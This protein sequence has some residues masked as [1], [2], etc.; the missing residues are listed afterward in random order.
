MMPPSGCTF[1]WARAL[2][3][4][5]A[6]TSQ[7]LTQSEVLKFVKG[8]AADYA[9]GGSEYFDAFARDAS[10][11]AVSVPTRID[12]LEEYKSG[13]QKNFAEGQNRRTQVLSPEV[14]ILGDDA[15]LVTFHNRIQV[16]DV[17]TNNRVTMVIQRD[18]GKLEVSHLHVS[19]LDT[20]HLRPSVDGGR[21]VSVLEER[22]AT[23]IGAVGTPK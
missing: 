8:F 5:V 1:L 15:A 19:P 7:A 12:S 6:M 16:N 23:A 20:P 18:G 13:F 9:A 3:W 4:D 14:R 22:V 21:Q 10:F 17:T 2:D 11:F